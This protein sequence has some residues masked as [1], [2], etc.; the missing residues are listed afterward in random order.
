MVCGPPTASSTAVLIASVPVPKA[1]LLPI[2]VKP[3]VE[4]GGAGIGVR[5]GERQRAGSGLRVRL[6]PATP[7]ITAEIV[8][9]DSRSPRPEVPLIVNV[10]RGV[11][12]RPPEKLPRCRGPNSR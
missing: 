9:V 4:H 10:R 11:D 5:A 12:S 8:S 7:L 6:V 3:G 2:S 1:V